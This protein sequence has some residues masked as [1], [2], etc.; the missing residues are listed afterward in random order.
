MW[1]WQVSSDCG[2]TLRGWPH[3]CASRGHQTTPFTVEKPPGRLSKS[4]ADGQAKR[5]RPLLRPKG[6]LGC[7]RRVGL[8]DGDTSDRRPRS[9]PRTRPGRAVLPAR[10]P[11]ASVLLAP[12]HHLNT[13]PRV[14]RWW[15]KDPRLPAWS[16]T[17]SPALAV[18]RVEEQPHRQV[19]GRVARAG[20]PVPDRVV[21]R[22][23]GERALAQVVSLG[24]DWVRRRS[25][26]GAAAWPGA[27][28]TVFAAAPGGMEKRRRPGG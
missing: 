3:S 10:P 19:G 21:R 26:R 27:G 22:P 15:C 12:T 17:A 8:R 23:Q 18:P 4:G 1:N 5:Q 6:S 13:V 25:R 2:V 11:A 16:V 28:S 20:L 9:S 24:K 7:R 14:R